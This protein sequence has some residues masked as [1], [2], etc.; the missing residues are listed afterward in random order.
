ML[1]VTLGWS[2]PHTW[3]GPYPASP[4]PR[5]CVQVVSEPGPL[6]AGGVQTPASDASRSGQTPVGG[7]GRPGR[8]DSVVLLVPPSLLAPIQPGSLAAGRASTHRAWLGGRGQVSRAGGAGKVPASPVPGVHLHAWLPQLPRVLGANV[9]RAAQP[10]GV[11]LPL[12]GWD[13]S[14]DWP[15]GL[16]VRPLR[17]VP[18][19]QA[20]GGQ[21]R[22]LPWE[23]PP[24]LRWAWRVCEL[25]SSAPL[26]LGL[27]EGEAGG[28][29]GR[30]PGAGS[31]AHEQAS[32]QL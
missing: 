14:R 12:R 9:H 17:P 5:G 26:R 30:F 8:A 24:A 4:Q 7:G 22:P 3:Q 28:L 11:R 1:T 18:F 29:R 32:S 21:E 2:G 6:P 13:S 25:A 31:H 16:V 27:G 10:Q 19:P 23:A 15:R 20:R